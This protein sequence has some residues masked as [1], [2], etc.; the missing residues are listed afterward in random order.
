MIL[1]KTALHRAMFEV[2]ADPEDGGGDGGSTLQLIGEIKT[3]ITNLGTTWEAF[4]KTNEELLKA[5]ADGK[6]VTELEAK[7]TK[8]ST[9]LD[10]LSASKKTVEETLLK[11]QRPNMG[12]DAKATADLE[13]ELKG[14]NI[15]RKTLSNSHTEP[16]TVDQYAAYKSA[17]EK[18]VRKGSID[19]LNEAEKKAML[20]GDDPNGGYFLPAP[21]IGRIVK[22]QWEMSPI[23]QL[24]TVMS[25][26]SN[27]V[28]GLSDN[29]EASAGWVGETDARPETGT[30]KVGKYRIEAFE[31]YANPRITQTLLDDAAVDVEAWLADKVSSKFARLESAAFVTGTGVGQPRGFTT[32]PFNQTADDTRAWGTIESVKTGV[33]GDFAA[34]SPA[35]ILFDLI[36]RFRPFYLQGAEWLARREAIAKIRKL[37]EATTNAYMWQ[38]GLQLGQ[39]DR[40]LGYNLRTDQYL[41]ALGANGASM[42]LADWK[43]FYLIVDRMGVRTLRDPFTDK[44]YVR[45]YTTKRVGGGVV[46][47]EAAKAIEFKT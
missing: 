5:K 13:L 30:P 46:N 9:D 10:A 29:D 31:M 25:I 43:E 47:F 32:Y 7:L 36:A 20:A 19:A 28:E 6:S 45:F 35:D 17:F 15:I 27:V 38:P 22:R 37:K 11:L 12:G 24:A 33:N 42:W 34:S 8:I 16:F 44:P 39:P 21:V 23:R 41:P 18:M 2:K 26:S 4:K 40:L 3:T 1:R 14:F